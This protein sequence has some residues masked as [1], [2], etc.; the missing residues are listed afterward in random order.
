MKIISI[1]DNGAASPRMSAG[2]DSAVLRTGDP[3]F[4]PDHLGPW[5]GALCPALRICRLGLNVPE[6]AARSYYDAITAVH[7]LIPAPGNPLGPEL[8]AMTDRAFAPGTWLPLD[9]ATPATSRIDLAVESKGP[10]DAEPESASVSF[11]LASLGA[12]RAIASLSRLA[13][14]KMG[15]ILLFRHISLPSG[16]A[17][18]PDGDGGFHGLIAASIGGQRCLNLKTR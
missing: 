5:S 10:G 2:A 7:V 6:R 14:V 4:V 17:L 11:S 13:T 9:P 12:D 18:C 8:V 16:P 15:D 1:F 3:L